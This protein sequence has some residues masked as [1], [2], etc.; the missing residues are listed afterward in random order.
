MVVCDSVCIRVGVMLCVNVCKN[1][2]HSC[3]CKTRLCECHAYPSLGLVVCM[4]VILAS[5]MCVRL[6]A[7]IRRRTEP[8][9]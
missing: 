5:V 8:I 1:N 2:N 4:R 7:W 3:E 9:V 6:C